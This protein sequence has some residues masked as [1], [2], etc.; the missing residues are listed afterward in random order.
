MTVAMIA[1]MALAVGCFIPV[2]ANAA[3][4]GLCFGDWPIASWEPAG[5]PGYT[6]SNWNN[7]LG[8]E[9]WLG[10][11]HAAPQD[12]SGAWLPDM[13]V[14]WYG[15]AAWTGHYPTAPE[16]G[17]RNIFWSALVNRSKMS[18]NS[19]VKLGGIPYDNY[20]VVV[21]MVS[22]FPNQGLEVTMPDEPTYCGQPLD[23][24][25]DGTWVQALSTDPENPTLGA[26][27]ALFED[28]TGGWTQIYFTHRTAGLMQTEGWLAGIQI[29][30]AEAPP[31]EDIIPEP[32]GLALIPLALLAVRRRRRGTTART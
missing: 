26:S 1:L 30:E 29:V 9:G 2:S 27:Y 6:Q 23:T 3:S 25:F 5:A 19:V 15:D 12:D 22:Y 13:T 20:D 11:A 32:A 18:E 7:C 14:S 10:A 4:I 24:G 16:V 31:D 28:R 8:A 17:D 21:Y